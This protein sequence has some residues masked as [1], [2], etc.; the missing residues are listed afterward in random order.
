MVW[1]GLGQQGGRPAKNGCSRSKRHWSLCSLISKSFWKVSGWREKNPNCSVSP[2]NLLVQ[3][4]HPGELWKSPKALLV[5][6]ESDKCAIQV[7]SHTKLSKSSRVLS[8]RPSMPPPPPNETTAGQLFCQC[9]QDTCQIICIQSVS[10]VSGESGGLRLI[11]AS[12]LIWT[13]PF[14]IFLSALSILRKLKRCTATNSLHIF[15]FYMVNALCGLNS[16]QTRW[17]YKFSFN[18][19][20]LLLFSRDLWMLRCLYRWRSHGVKHCSSFTENKPP[21]MSSRQE[22]LHTR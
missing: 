1:E 21:G 11:A 15:T 6:R 9:L 4:R 19:K 22:T 3:W 14:L 16:N 5:Y 20:G 12:R 10:T 18:N 8:A 2:G 7:N 17:S 13:L